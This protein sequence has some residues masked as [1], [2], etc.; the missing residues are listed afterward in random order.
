MATL[1]I[2]IPICT[3]SVMGRPDMENLHA[4]R[5]NFCFCLPIYFLQLKL[6][7]CACHPCR[8]DGTLF[9]PLPASSFPT[10]VTIDSGLM[11]PRLCNKYKS[12]AS[13]T[14][15]GTTQRRLSWPLCRG[16]RQN[17]ER[18][19]GCDVKAN[20]CPARPL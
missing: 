4:Y 14:K 19:G 1:V 15:I 5:C 2:P 3:H 6:D 7:E 13:A 17:R 16:A 18:G 11:G 9:P 12:L 20:Y 10:S 8:E